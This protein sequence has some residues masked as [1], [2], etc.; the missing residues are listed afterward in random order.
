MQ[1]ADTG[2]QYLTMMKVR[3]LNKKM[4][5][6]YSKLGKGKV[7]NSALDGAILFPPMTFGK[8][9][10]G[11]QASNCSADA[12]VIISDLTFFLDKRQQAA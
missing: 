4:S 2:N 10:P 5:S 6:V 8:L 7:I 9:E 1:L 12:K 3:M 11:F